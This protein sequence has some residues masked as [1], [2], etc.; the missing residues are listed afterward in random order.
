MGS[1]QETYSAELPTVMG[2][3]LLS[4]IAALWRKELHHPNRFI[5]SDSAYPGQGK[6]WRQKFS[7]SPIRSINK[8]TPSPWASGH[9]G[10]SDNQRKVGGGS[11]QTRASGAT[12][13]GKA[14]NT[15][16]RNARSGKERP[17][18]Y[19][20]SRAR[21]GSTNKGTHARGTRTERIH[22]EK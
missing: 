14:G 10:V 16:S 18:G 3:H 6:T 13:E 5:G 8:S 11:S 20:I 21:E 1:Q 12:G 19:G 17:V 2:R 7:G 9:R 22:R 4:G 15:F